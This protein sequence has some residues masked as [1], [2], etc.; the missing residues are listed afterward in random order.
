MK[1]LLPKGALPATE[2]FP[3]PVVDVDLELLKLLHSRVVQPGNQYRLGGKVNKLTADS[4]I[5][6]SI[7]IDCSGYV[8]WIMH[9]ATHDELVMPDGSVQQG[10]W[11]DACGFKRS[12]VDACY[13]KDDVLRIVQYR[14]TSGVGHI[15]LVLNGETI[16]SHGGTGPDSRPW[17]GSGWQS[18]CT[19]WVL[20]PPR[21]D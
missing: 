12:S 16:E 7:G 5:V 15:A 6:R 19:V 14:P 11:L 3:Y 9:R 1:N 21:S 10:D 4:S 20:T 18:A 8:R 17:T 2:A 13:L